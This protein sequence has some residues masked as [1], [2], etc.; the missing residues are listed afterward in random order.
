[1]ESKKKEDTDKLSA[2]GK[3]QVGA[4]IKT[5]GWNDDEL[6]QA[7]TKRILR[8]YK[9][10]ISQKGLNYNNVDDLIK[11]GCLPKNAT[12]NIDQNFP[13]FNQGRVI[14]NFQQIDQLICD[15]TL[16]GDGVSPT[17]CKKFKEGK[18]INR[19]GFKIICETLGV[20]YESVVECSTIKKE[21]Y[22]EDK[23]QKKLKLA[24]MQL[25]H[26]NQCYSFN[27]LTQNRAISIYIKNDSPKVLRAKWLVSC[28]I[29][30]F[31]KIILAETLSGVNL[32]SDPLRINFKSTGKVSKARKLGSL[33]EDLF[34]ELVDGLKNKNLRT[35]LTKKSTPDL[36]AQAT[37][38]YLN[39]RDSIILVFDKS[40]RLNDDIIQEIT[41]QFWERL[42]Q[43][44]SPY[45]KIDSCHCLLLCYV[46]EKDRTIPNI[47][48]TMNVVN[49]FKREELKTWMNPL[50]V[51]SLFAIEP[52][53][54]DSKIEEIWS[55]FN[56]EQAQPEALLEKIYQSWDCCRE[57]YEEWETW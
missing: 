41:K 25:D 52:A 46:G 50:D 9:T 3:E 51:L 5:K 23:Q 24:L 34:N 54:I 36:I 10:H 37:A 28:L 20:E 49:T 16:I 57:W 35:K 42:I 4:V 1:M 47:L 40:D 21:M 55:T 30:N 15:Q 39:Q 2:K 38:E 56:C 27:K 43:E 31:K 53:E 26:N 19:K 11:Q 45:L 8:R 7:A 48:T 13:G 33:S 6:S 17:T 22:N 12:Y 32:N 29:Y 14:L 44:V 18:Y